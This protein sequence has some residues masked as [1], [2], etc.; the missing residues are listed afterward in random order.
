MWGL[1]LGCAAPN[2][3]PPRP[4]RLGIQAQ[5]PPRPLSERE[6]P[7]RGFLTRPLATWDG[8]AWLLEVWPDGSLDGR[9]I[10]WRCAGG[11]L[12]PIP[13]DPTRVRW[14]GGGSV[15]AVLRLGERELAQETLAL[16][17]G[18][19]LR[20]AGVA[21]GVVAAGPGVDG[22]LL[23]GAPGSPMGDQQ[24]RWGLADGQT[25]W[26]EDEA[27]RW[28]GATAG[29]LPPDRRGT[30][31]PLEADGCADSRWPRRVG[32]DHV[33]CASFDPA[34]RGRLDRLARGGET[35]P[36]PS[37]PQLRRATRT[38]PIE[39]RSA[40]A[41]DG[42][43][44][45][46]DRFVDWRPEGS[47]AR[48]LSGA[49][50]LGRPALAGDGFALARA[51]RVEW[52]ER[53]ANQRQQRAATPLNAPGALA[54]T[55]DWVAVREPEGVRLVGTARARSARI[56][57]PVDFLAAR[58]AWLFLASDA[59]RVLPLLGGV[60]HAANW[61]AGFGPD[62]EWFDDWL[63]LPRREQRLE[64]WGM[65]L[66][67]GLLS[68]VAGR[69]AWVEARGAA[70]GRLTV[71][72]GAWGTA[73]S[74]DERRSAVRVFEDA[75]SVPGGHGGA[76]DS[77]AG[78]AVV[79]F[80]VGPGRVAL[81]HAGWGDGVVELWVDDRRLGEAPMGAEASPPAWNRVG[82]L[83][84]GSGLRRVELR[85]RGATAGR[86]DAVRVEES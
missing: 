30:A 13:T 6:R 24:M 35:S 8:D 71:R 3:L 38:V 10:E 5:G 45:L 53:G 15:T 48:V 70:A 17:A 56:A 28:V 78:D 22:L 34:G 44:A 63:L 37:P 1:L 86:R 61:D 29:L 74:L 67:T 27:G 39:A 11:R 57:G 43:V 7:A 81:D 79:A 76:H 80:V 62:V 2:P 4:T 59:A 68:P 69:A 51:D 46:G 84:A 52:G 14:S 33:G 75:G 21:G 20:I 82:L 64:L 25:V 60:A 77:A 54:R 23:G 85:F 16:S 31:V 9:S 66:P 55:P 12:S 32:L 49:E 42:L 40:T 73:G 26:G 58:G 36:L 19:G 72:A 18:P 41:G 50:A 83:P 65:H 47:S